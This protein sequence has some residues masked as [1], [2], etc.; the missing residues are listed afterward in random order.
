MR[1]EHL[2]ELLT[3][4]NVTVPTESSAA[5]SGAPAVGGKRT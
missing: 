4:N 2:S 5:T 3:K 1:N